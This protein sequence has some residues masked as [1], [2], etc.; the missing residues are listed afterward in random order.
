VKHTPSL[1]D[2]LIGA[3]G[4]KVDRFVSAWNLQT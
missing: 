1:W 2:S 4:I 3:G